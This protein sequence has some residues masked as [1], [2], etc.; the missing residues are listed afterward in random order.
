MCST[1]AASLCLN[2][3]NP[4]GN[5]ACTTYITTDY[6]LRPVPEVVGQ[7]RLIRP[8]TASDQMRLPELDILRGRVPPVVA[9]RRLRCAITIGSG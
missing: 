9:R 7:E 3:S 4:I 5:S 2:T 8:E 6:A 1:R